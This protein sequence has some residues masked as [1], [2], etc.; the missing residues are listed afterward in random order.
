MKYLIR[1]VFSF[2][3]TAAAA[4]NIEVSGTVTEEKRSI[5]FANIYISGT[6]QGTS[7]DMKGNFT[8][9][10]KPENTELTIQAIGFK[11]RR[12]SIDPE[13]YKETELNIAM[14]EDALGLDQVVISAT[15]NRINL[16]DAPVIVN[17]LGSKLFNATQSVSVAESL[18]FQPGVRVETNCQNCGFTQVRL[19]GLDGSYTQVL[20]NSRAVFS[21][22]NSVYGLE[23]IPTSILDRVEVVR[24]GGS[25][26]FGSNAIAGTI[27]IITKEPVLNTWNIA[28]NISLIDGEIPDRTLNFAGSVVTEDLNSGV[29]IYGMNRDRA[30]Y[31]ANGDGF[32]EIT[33][34]TNNTLG[35]KA[36]LKPSETS[37]I[38]L[39][40]TALK[41]YRRGGD[42]LELAPHLTDIT[43]QLDHNTFIGGLT[44]EFSNP[45]MTNNYSVYVSGQHTDRKSF[46]GGL[47]GGRTA[48]DSLA[49]SNAY[50]NTS[51]LALL[52]GFQFTHNFKNNDVLTTGVEYNRSRTEDDIAG[53]KRFIDQEVNSYAAFGQ[54]EWKPVENF[55]ALVGAR[56]D[57]VDILGEYA[58]ENVERKSKINQTVLSPRLTI[59]YDITNELQFRGGYA[60]GF[61]A[62]QAFNEDLHI[63]SVGGEPQFVILSDDL[64]TEYSN[65]YT[66]SFN[67]SKSIN[68]LQTDFLLEGF[69]TELIDPFTTVSTG[70]SLPN[71]SILK[72]VRN[73]SGAYVTGTNFEIGVSPSSDLTFQLGGT[74]QQSIYKEDQILYE[75]DPASEREE[76]IIISEFVRNPDF[77]GYLNVNT[78]PFE[79]FSVDLTGTY[80]G[81]MTIPKVINANGFLELRESP[82]FWDM[83]LKLSQHLDITENFHI[84]LSTGVQNVFNAYQDDFDTGPT[85][86]SDYIYGPSRPR[87]FFFGIK[88]GNLHD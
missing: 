43:E 42:R 65:A 17:V 28:S 77:Y 86:D 85:R 26:L 63:S 52:G 69:Y 71:G 73:G 60:R 54:Y 81:K 22:L 47:G 84:N 18:N 15:R 38:T 40:L 10:L 51:D 33:E 57:H 19:N 13:D 67:Y 11:T 80:T 87:T 35:A 66:A 6:N 88:F 25:A 24:S 44:Y 41:E 32:T 20:I 56:L 30:A 4:Q 70:A 48:Q 75:A 8:I 7:A 39:D 37:K 14:Q 16:K 55:T 68:K 49:A 36:F 76:D 9:S 72:E 34:L 29:T 3:F 61:R 53:Y 82:S 64:K 1:I 27:N 58:V 78:S 2:V 62:P 79:N 31:D 5:P 50:G 45:E 12:I 21:A 46:Y 23:Q 74:F 83:N 59:L